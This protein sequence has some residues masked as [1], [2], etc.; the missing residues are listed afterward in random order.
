MDFGWDQKAN[1]YGKKQRGCSKRGAQ[2]EQRS[3]KYP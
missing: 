3:S 2:Q 1:D